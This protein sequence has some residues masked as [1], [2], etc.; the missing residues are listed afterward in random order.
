MARRRPFD[1][2]RIR[3][4]AEPL[5]GRPAADQPLS[6]RQVNE[7]VAGAVARHLP[8]TLH[9][10]GEIGNF[11]QPHSGHLYLTLKDADSE[12]RA[13]MWRS[14]AA[15][16]KFAPETGMEV[17]ATGSIEVYLPRGTYQL[18]V[19]KLEP[20]GVGALEVAFRQLRERLEREGLFEPRRKQ[21][22]PRYPQRIGIVTSPTGAA[23]RDIL[24][25]LERRY[26]VLDILIHPVRVQGTGAAAEIAAAIHSFNA[27]AAA[28]GGIDLLIVG[29]GGGSLEDLWAFNEEIV[30]RAIAASEIPIISGVGHEI[31]VTISDLVADLRA[32]TPTAAAE[33]CTPV[34]TDILTVLAERQLRLTRSMRQRFALAEAQFRAQLAM[35]PLA[36]PLRRIADQGQ[37]CD[38]RLQDL[39]EAWR[40]QQRS[41]ADRL[42]N[43]QQRLWHLAAGVR[44]QSLARAVDARRHRLERALITR[45]F[46]LERMQS[47]MQAR[48]ARVS[49]EHRLAGT[50]ADLRHAIRQLNA[51]LPARVEHLRERLES[52]LRALAG[53]APQQILKRGYS[54]VRDARTRSV[55]QTLSAVHDHQRLTIQVADG[56]FRATASDPRQQ[57][58]FDL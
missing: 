27:H 29:R 30:A 47:Q 18:I 4:T 42:H 52:Q 54:I 8:A 33:L 57:A 11:T 9:V 39:R 44:F 10:V 32:P 46:A 17:I 28:L 43:L 1:P 6:V 7:L 34:L 21:P 19:R 56:E 55:V 50:L 24:R 12:L 3:K 15:N 5:P 38:E 51:M 22:L 37:R 53:C 14:T 58:L 31:D 26:P 49:P 25:T 45:H 13:V 41:A 36:R 35:E 48:L 16:L 23:I 40:A 2:S 20:R